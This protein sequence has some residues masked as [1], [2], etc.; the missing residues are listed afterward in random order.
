MAQVIPALV[1]RDGSKS[2]RFNILIDYE[3]RRLAYEYYDFT[4]TILSDDDINDYL[5]FV[6]NTGFKDLI[7]NRKIKNLVDYMVGIEA[8]LDS[9][10]RKNRSGSVMEDIVEAFIK[11]FCRKGGLRYLKEANARKIKQEFGNEVPVDKSSR[12]YD[13]VI[14]FGRELCII[15]T[16]FYGGGGSKLK[17]TAG[18]YRDLFDRLGGQYK[19]V[20]ITDGL[21]WNTSRLPL[22]ETFDHNDYLF[23]LC[24][25]ENDVLETLIN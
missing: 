12:R 16:N 21:G 14:D 6:S 10:A 18:E 8:G 7:V 22:R 3:N 5:K 23:N 20:W 4:K 24:M 25:L 9:N 13:F 15:E 1:V 17:S 2:K 19:F 11:D